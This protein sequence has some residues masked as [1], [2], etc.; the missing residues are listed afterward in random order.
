MDNLGGHTVPKT[1]RL[2]LKRQWAQGKEHLEKAAQEILALQ[3]EFKPTHPDYAALAE[4]TLQALYMT[5]EGWDAFARNA[6]GRLPNK[7]SDWR[8]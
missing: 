6:W 4:Y 8:A 7:T 5:M 2:Q 1:K 3:E